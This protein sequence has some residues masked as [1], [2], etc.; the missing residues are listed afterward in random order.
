MDYSAAGKDALCCPILNRRTE[1]ANRRGETFFPPFGVA[2]ARILIPF[3]VEFVHHVL[4]SFQK[5]PAI[6]GF[7]RQFCMASS[8]HFFRI[9]LLHSSFGKKWITSDGG[10][11]KC[12]MHVPFLIGG[13]SRTN[14]R[15]ET[16][17]R[18]F[19]S[20]RRFWKLGQKSENHGCAFFVFQQ[21][22]QVSLLPEIICNRCGLQS[23]ICVPLVT[24]HFGNT[25]TR[26]TK[27]VSPVFPRMKS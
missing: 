23:K 17:F 10:Q 27:P 3:I 14:R 4:Q 5:Q 8:E 2:S 18:L 26:L 19:Q 9:R 15:G 13:R 20:H 6:R 11:P 7:A 12:A 22:P 16:R 1:S 24:N 21:N 25:T